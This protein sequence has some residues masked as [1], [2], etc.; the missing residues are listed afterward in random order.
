M[1]KYTNLK[2]LF[3]AIAYAIRSKTGR[4]ESIIADDFPTAIAAIETDKTEDEDGIITGNLVEYTNDRVTSVA[5]CRFFNFSR[6]QK[7][8]LPR[9]SYVSNN[10]FTD[11]LQLQNIDIP[12]VVTISDSAFTGTSITKLICPNLARIER[13]CCVG[14]S[15]L[16]KVDMLGHDPLS[17]DV[18]GYISGASFLRCNTLST[19]IIR[20]TV[21]VC[22]LS[23]VDAFED[24]PIA[25]GDGYIYVPR[26]LIEDYKV[27]NN[28][29]AF[30]SQFRAI[31]DYTVDGTVTGELDSSKI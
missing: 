12:A 23:E 5:M 14:C 31:E 1:P 27:A 17:P 15:Y 20:S 29:S 22:R 4:S 26:A 9:V 21:T 10:S 25:D 8:N 30:A 2:D 28:W 11:C 19:L 13:Y 7:V 3:T 24:T 16:K 18:S 6:L